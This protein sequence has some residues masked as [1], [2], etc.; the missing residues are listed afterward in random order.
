MVD[1]KRKCPFECTNSKQSHS[2]HCVQQQSFYSFS[3]FL[4]FFFLSNFTFIDRQRSQ[5]VSLFFCFFSSHSQFQWQMWLEKKRESSVNRIELPADG[6]IRKQ[7]LMEDLLFSFA[8]KSFN[9]NWQIHVEMVECFGAHDSSTQFSSLYWVQ[10]LYNVFR[11]LSH[12]LIMRDYEES[13]ILPH[14]SMNLLNN[15]SFIRFRL[16]KVDEKK[17]T[18]QILQI[19]QKEKYGEKKLLKMVTYDEIKCE[20]STWLKMAHIVDEEYK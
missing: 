19:S 7:F 15:F 5:W 9:L 10:A 20:F 1:C 13:F 3:L 4:I 8:V 14:F 2:I 16:E 12:I 6:C 18:I 11:T 17:N